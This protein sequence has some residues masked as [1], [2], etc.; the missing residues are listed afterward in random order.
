MIYSN[1]PAYDVSIMSFDDR[2]GLACFMCSFGDMMD[3]HYFADST[4]SML[5]HIDA[6]VRKGDL[7]PEGLKEQLLADDQVNYSQPS[8]Q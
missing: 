1:I 2:D 6:H 3:S 4:E 7:I 8:G 5:G